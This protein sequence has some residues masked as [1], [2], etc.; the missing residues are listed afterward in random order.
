MSRFFMTTTGSEG[1]VTPLVRLAASLQQRGHEVVLFTHH[2]F[3]ERFALSGV[4]IVPF[5]T[6]DDYQ[7]FIDDGALLND[8]RTAAEC[9]RRHFI[10]NVRREC[11]L[12]EEHGAGPETV[13]VTS[14]TPGITARLVAER[15]RARCVSIL[16]YPAHASTM[17]TYEEFLWRCFAADLQHLREHHGLP[18]LSALRPWWRMPGLHLAVWPEWFA[19]VSVGGIE[20][21]EYGGFQWQD[22]APEEEVEQSLRQHQASVLMTSGTGNFGDRIFFARCVEACD[23]LG[24]EPLLVGRALRPDASGDLG[25]AR[26]IRSVPSLARLMSRSRVVV[27]HGGLGTVGQAVAAGVPQLIGAFGG[28]RPNNGALVEAL[29]AGAFLPKYRWSV[30]EICAALSRLLEDEEMARRCRSL[31][32]RL[33][34]GAGVAR[35]CDALESMAEVGAR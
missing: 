26:W 14:E 21:L 34:S 5:D 15:W 7:A 29:G 27:H 25:A 17:P 32:G 16:L 12:M 6:A 10:P 28:D 19:A 18:A 24:L 31:A 2:P 20:R 22:D 8:P 13:L 23:R 9:F 3:R 4:H 30:D 33:S 35:A 1:C 11:A